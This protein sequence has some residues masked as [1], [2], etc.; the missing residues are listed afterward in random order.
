MIMTLSLIYGIVL[1]IL[2]II[3]PIAKAYDRAKY[4]KKWEEHHMLENCLLTLIWPLLLVL[5]V[6][7]FTGKGIFEYGIKPIFRFL[8]RSFGRIGIWLANNYK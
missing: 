4:G 5:F 1:L 6:L 2:L 7:I 3:Q 8:D